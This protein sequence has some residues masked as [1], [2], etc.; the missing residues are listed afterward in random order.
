MI[1]EKGE[2][3]ILKE[4]LEN[5]QK[6]YD[7]LSVQFYNHKNNEYEIAQQVFASLQFYRQFYGSSGSYQNYLADILSILRQWGKNQSQ[8]Y[9]GKFLIGLADLLEECN[10]GGEWPGLNKKS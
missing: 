2:A 6:K 5:L 4:Q 3:L 7:S 9:K 10:K 8:P 1:R